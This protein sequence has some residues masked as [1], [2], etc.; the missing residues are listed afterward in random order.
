MVTWPWDAG[1]RP[2]HASI[3]GS[4]LEADLGGCPVSPVFA[5][6]RMWALILSI[7]ATASAFWSSSC[8]LYGDGRRSDAEWNLV[9]CSAHRS[10]SCCTQQDEMAALNDLPEN[11][12]VI[13]APSGCYE[14]LNYMQ[15]YFCSSEQ[16]DWTDENGKVT[17]CKSLCYRT[18]AHCRHG[19]V[20]GVKLAHKYSGHMEF[21]QA[22]N[23]EVEDDCGDKKCE[24]LNKFATCYGITSDPV[25]VVVKVG[26]SAYK[27][28][29]GW[30]TYSRFGRG[31]RRL[32]EISN[33]DDDEDAAEDDDGSGDAATAAINAT[34]QTVV[35][36]LGQIGQML[37]RL[38]ARSAWP[39]G[40]ARATGCAEF[41]GSSA[42]SKMAAIEA[43]VAQ[44]V[45]IRDAMASIPLSDAD[46]APEE[47]DEED[48][49]A[50]GAAPQEAD[51][52]DEEADDAMPQD[53]SGQLEDEQ[54]EE[55]D[56]AMLQLEDE[57][58]GARRPLKE[59]PPRN[60]DGTPAGGGNAA[61]R[62]RLAT[63]GGD[64]DVAY[65]P[66]FGNREPS[67]QWSLSNCSWYVARAQDHRAGG[68]VTRAASRV[69]A[70]TSQTAVATPQRRR[71]CWPSGTPRPSPTSA[72]SARACSTSCT[73]TRATLRSPSGSPP[74]IR[75]STCARASATGC[76]RR[77]ATPFTKARRSRSRS[78]RARTCASCS[79]STWRTTTKRVASTS[80]T[81]RT[82]SRTVGSS[83]RTRRMRRA[84]V[85]CRGSRPSARSS[86]SPRSACPTT[87]RL[88]ALR[89]ARRA[90]ARRPARAWAARP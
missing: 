74:S 56:D 62:R 64:D 24:T 16:A 78:R 75:P 23:F 28:G 58:D 7:S 71:L 19:Y 40:D 86:R 35:G 88:A 33:D 72:A 17:I 8:P 67:P 34:T 57:E 31:V 73:A 39:C 12:L 53:N 11:G 6:L 20:G 26:A 61:S 15:C 83:C 46:A 9:N 79:S 43:L 30:Y 45:A 76:T 1:P 22:Q 81:A 3:I 90:A 37:S 42:A 10:D 13:D 80:T 89:R 29:P 25:A 38:T 44:G 60:S 48:D 51:E 47:D 4:I 87:P 69:C 66:Y 41:A 27:E 68:V 49:E 5:M 50:D 32:E 70:G 36:P 59:E 18:W 63:S 77:A 54:D 55:A 65:C 84:G 85:P 2:L 52:K 14:V 21:C 82:A